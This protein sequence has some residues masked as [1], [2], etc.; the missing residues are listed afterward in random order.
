[1]VKRSMIDDKSGK[2]KFF[3]T[4]LSLENKII[5]YQKFKSTAHSVWIF[6]SFFK[7][8]AKNANIDLQVIL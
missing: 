2:S 4:A 5:P 6:L 7:W 1:M 3:L 8:I